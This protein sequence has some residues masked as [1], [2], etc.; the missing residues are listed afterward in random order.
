MN[1]VSWKE[2]K[3]EI[4]TDLLMVMMKDFEKEK[5]KGK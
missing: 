3:M 2:R 4:E 1:W 5:T